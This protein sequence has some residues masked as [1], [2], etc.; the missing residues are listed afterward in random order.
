MNNKKTRMKNKYMVDNID[1]DK[2]IENMLEKEFLVLMKDMKN[3]K[4]Q[5]NNVRDKLAELKKDH[6]FINPPHL[7]KLRQYV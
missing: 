7:Y 3:I 1:D 6:L 2:P 4:M 5:I